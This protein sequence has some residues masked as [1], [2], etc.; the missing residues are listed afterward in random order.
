LRDTKQ[1][2]NSTDPSPFRERDLDSNAEEFFVGWAEEFPI[3]APLTLRIHLQQ[4][5]AEDPREL[6]RDAVH[7]YF[8][9]RTR[10]DDVEFRRL[11]KQGRSSL[12]IGLVFLGCCLGLI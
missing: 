7:N 4:W 2:F 12:L 9:Y 3:D 1:L 8:A 5:P 6:I 10:Q 11:M